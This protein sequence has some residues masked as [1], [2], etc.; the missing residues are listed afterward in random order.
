MEMKSEREL[1]EE[2][3]QKLRRV[4]RLLEAASTYA[5]LLVS[6]LASVKAI[7]PDDVGDLVEIEL[8]AHEALAKTPRPGELPPADKLLPA[9]HEALFEA[10]RTVPTLERLANRALSATSDEKAAH[11]AKKLLETTRELEEA[12]STAAEAWKKLFAASLSLK[13]TE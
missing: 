13:G 5:Y 4:A 2:L 10:L 12:G 7:A 6:R 8:A 11:Y 3:T 1:R 9:A